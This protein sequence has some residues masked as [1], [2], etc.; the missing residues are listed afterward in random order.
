MP[1]KRLCLSGTV[2]SRKAAS[3]KLNCQ[4]LNRGR[5]VLPSAIAN[6]FGR[7]EASFAPNPS[8]PKEDAGKP[9]RLHPAA[10]HHRADR[11]TV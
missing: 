7:P 8:L 11:N 6:S 3:G 5:W 1:L 10:R 9:L 2:K 4:G